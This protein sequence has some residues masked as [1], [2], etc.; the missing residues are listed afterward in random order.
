MATKALQ[1]PSARTHLIGLQ[2]GEK[3]EADCVRVESVERGEDDLLTAVL[4]FTIHE[5]VAVGEEQE[6]VEQ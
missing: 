2:I 6:A 3:A 4:I 1:P 5:A